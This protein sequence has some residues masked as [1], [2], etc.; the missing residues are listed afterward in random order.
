MEEQ[1]RKRGRPTDYTDDL[2]DLICDG[3]VQGK[4]LNKICT[5]EGMP[6]IATVFRWLGK[7]E[8]FRDKYAKAKEQGVEARAEHLE[9]IGDEAIALAQSVDPKASNAVVQAYKLKS[10]NAKWAMSKLKP[11]KYGD[12]IDMTTNGKDLPTPILGAIIP[13]VSSNNGDEEGSLSHEA[14]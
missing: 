2:V 5:E 10:D 14:H 8:I 11:K 9:E 6:D 4:S 7:Y 13:N 1:P 3:L 12:K